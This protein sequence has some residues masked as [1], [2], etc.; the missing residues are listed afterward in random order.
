MGCNPTI[1]DKAEIV[2]EPFIL[3]FDKMVYDKEI[4]VSL[5]HFQ[6]PEMKFEDLNVLKNQL[7]QDIEFTK[8]YFLI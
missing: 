8:S 5:L 7:A 3:N 6:R 4:V 1:D 2:I